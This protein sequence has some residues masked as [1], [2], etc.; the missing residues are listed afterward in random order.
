MNIFTFTRSRILSTGL[1]ALVLVCLVIG[2]ESSNT[3]VK[4]HVFLLGSESKQ[5]E[6]AIYAEKLASG[7]SSALDIEDLNSLDIILLDSRFV[8][9]KVS[10]QFSPLDAKDDRI[11]NV[12]DN[13]KK[14][15]SKAVT[16]LNP[17]DTQLR[18]YIKTIVS[19]TT[20]EPS[21][22]YAIVGRL[23]LCHNEAKGAVKQI[24]QLNAADDAKPKLLWI[25][26]GSRK[27]DVQ[28]RNA[29]ES[30]Y[31]VVRETFV[32]PNYTDCDAGSG[33]QAPAAAVST[34]PAVESFVI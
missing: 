13:L 12:V 9:S 19:K 1:V 3:E 26:P 30:K 15:L 32:V 29:F 34:A 24:A 20:T 22:I 11:G 28:L 14:Q 2:C 33:A 10:V 21:A 17:D 16:K 5:E 25:I 7:I 8:E 27:T 31:E 4:L 6:K 18:E 23:P